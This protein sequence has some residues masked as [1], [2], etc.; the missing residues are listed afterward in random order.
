MAHRLRLTPTRPSRGVTYSDGRVDHGTG[1]DCPQI[2]WYRP[3]RTQAGDGATQFGYFPGQ[4]LDCG[5][6][7]GGPPRLGEVGETLKFCKER[8]SARWG[9]GW[10]R[11]VTSLWLP[12]A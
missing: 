2:G 12:G 3:L 9:F 6:V 5:T 11:R 10:H 1:D 4:L 8:C 7:L